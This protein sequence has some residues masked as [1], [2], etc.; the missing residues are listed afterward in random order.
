[1][2][3]YQNL[4][5]DNESP[6]FIDKYLSCKTLE[7]LKYITQFC[8][9]DYTNLYNP[10][11]LYTRYD[12]SITVAHMT[13]HFTHDKK[14]TI[15]ALLHDVGTPCFAHTID[16]VFGDYI[17]QESSE[18]DIVEMIKKDEY[19]MK[20]LKEDEID[21]DMLRDLTQYPILENK[22]PKLC[23]D[24]LDGV[25]HTCYIWLHTHPLED[26]K[27]VYEDITVLTNEDGLS[28]IGFKHKRE[29]MKFAKMV[30]VYAKEL[31][32][33]RDKY[34]SKYISELVKLSVERKLITLEDLYVKKETE[35]TDIFDK[36]FSTWKE[37][38][39]VSI[40]IGT[41]KKPVGFSISFAAKKRNTI[42]LVQV[43]KSSK[44]IVDASS[45][46][47]KIYSNLE[48]YHDYKYA[49]LETIKDI[50]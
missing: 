27:K 28:E 34:V 37:F 49:Y 19:L 36:N 22:S 35:I 18:K 39:Q 48:E 40:L 47:N 31:W 16:Y 46:V 44:R 9:A 24:R 38:E 20:C 14:S 42:P 2:K 43:G 8:G 23:T 7:R 26:I 4:F 3:E 5:M 25:L 45:I 11:F 6:I 21:L 13:W 10:L 15:A 50:F 32:G 17:N 41:E 1:M 33:N 12:H 30:T 29:A